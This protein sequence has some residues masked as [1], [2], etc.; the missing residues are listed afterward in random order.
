MNN[1]AVTWY[2]CP[3]G[4]R[5]IWTHQGRNSLSLEAGVVLAVG[6]NQGKETIVTVVLDETQKAVK[7]RIG[8][9]TWAKLTKR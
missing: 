4:S 2:N 6:R 3:K 7:V 9:L 1:G 5:V 8:D